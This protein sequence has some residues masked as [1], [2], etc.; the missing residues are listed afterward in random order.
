MPIPFRQ[1]VLS[2]ESCNDLLRNDDIRGRRWVKTASS[3]HKGADQRRILFDSLPDISIHSRMLRII[4]LGRASGLEMIQAFCE[5]IS[6][7]SYKY[8]PRRFIR[9]VKLSLSVEKLAAYRNAQLHYAQNRCSK[10]SA[11]EKS[12]VSFRLRCKRNLE[13]ISAVR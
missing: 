9:T 4:V 10:L 12:R 11:I 3:A 5:L 6:S 8:R 13:I 1:E 2:L 7:V